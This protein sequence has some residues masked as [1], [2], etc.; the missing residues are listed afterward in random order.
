[1]TEIAKPAAATHEQ[2]SIAAV[3]RVLRA[4]GGNDTC[5][6]GP[7]GEKAL[8]PESLRAV[9]IEAAGALEQGQAIRIVPA[10]KELTTQQAADLL[11]ISRPFLIRLLEAGQIPFRRVGTHRRLALADVLAYRTERSKKRR[12]VLGEMAR[13]A[14]KS[15]LYEG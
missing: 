12:A 11:N 13:T 2:Q 8:I 14:Q 5:I 6:I 10:N 3:Q 15:G 7:S 9:L 4:T 1:M